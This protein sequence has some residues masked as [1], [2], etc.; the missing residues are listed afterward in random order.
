MRRNATLMAEC[1]ESSTPD[2]TA[3]ARRTHLEKLTK[4][5]DAIIKVV[6]RTDAATKPLTGH[7]AW[8]RANAEWK[9]GLLFSNA[10]DDASQNDVGRCHFEGARC[11]N[12]RLQRCLLPIA[13]EPGRNREQSFGRASSRGRVRTRLHLGSCVSISRPQ[14]STESLGYIQR[15]RS[16]EIHAD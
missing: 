9:R 5:K 6:P 12:Q 11:V 15:E 1:K 8:V 14:G 7:D 4:V 2:D 13:S 3:E 16:H 10:G